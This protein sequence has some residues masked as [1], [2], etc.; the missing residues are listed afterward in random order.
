M[1]LIWPIAFFFL[2]GGAANELRINFTFF[3]VKNIDYFVTHKTMKFK[4]W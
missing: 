1:S 3:M 2:G 4:I